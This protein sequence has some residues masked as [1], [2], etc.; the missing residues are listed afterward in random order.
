ME[1]LLASGNAGKLE[2]F[3]ILLSRKIQVVSPAERRAALNLEAL[4]EVVED[5]TTYYE[6]ALKKAVAFQRWGGGAVLSDD[7]GLE[8]TGLQG[9]PG[10]NTAYFGGREATWPERWDALRAALEGKGEEDY[11][12]RFR[13]VLCYFDGSAPVFFE[14]TIE[15]R[16]LTEAR[17]VNGFGFDPIFM[18][19]EFQMP[20]GEMPPEYKNQVSH[21]AAAARAFLQWWDA[22]FA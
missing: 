13:A 16:V 3:R 9:G 22:R 21:R 17:G 2:E 12:A 18:S 7:S 5:G 19:K 11:R 15:G 1:L 8:V 6:N 14:G 20:F 4:P 10:V